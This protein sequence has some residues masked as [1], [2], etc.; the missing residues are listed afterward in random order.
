MTQNVPENSPRYSD[1]DI[2]IAET[3]EQE[4]LTESQMNY[5]K[6]RV[7]TLRVQANDLSQRLNDALNEVAMLRE[8]L[9]KDSDVEPEDGENTT[10]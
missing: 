9:P 6:R 5:L 4:S 10:P 3:A 8:Q 1:E 2:R 7:V